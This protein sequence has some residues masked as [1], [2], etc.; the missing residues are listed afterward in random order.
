[1]VYREK[2]DYGRAPDYLADRKQELQ[3]RQAQELAKEQALERQRAEASGL[4]LLA[5]EDRLQVLA[6]LKAN[7][8]VINREYGKLSLVVDTLPKITR[9]Y[10]AVK[11]LMYWR[12]IKRH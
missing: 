10:F 4:T 7:W 3:E 8:E 5:E 6:G 11:C 9:Y 12:L 1:M 2:A